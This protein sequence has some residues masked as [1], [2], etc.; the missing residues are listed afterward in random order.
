MDATRF[1]LVLSHT[2]IGDVCG[3]PWYRGGLGIR[4]GSFAVPGFVDGPNHSNRTSLVNRRAEE[5]GN[6]L[7]DG[8]LAVQESEPTGALPGRVL[9]HRYRRGP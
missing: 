9:R 7:V 2:H 8:R 4:R 1:D 5:I 6:V 3:N